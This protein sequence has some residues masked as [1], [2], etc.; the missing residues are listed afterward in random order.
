MDH[1]KLNTPVTTGL[2]ASSQ[3]A[4][5]PQQHNVSQTPAASGIAGLAEINQSDLIHI[6]KILQ[7]YNFKVIT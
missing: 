2:N 3:Q 4:D 1:L 5:Q 7:K 6:V